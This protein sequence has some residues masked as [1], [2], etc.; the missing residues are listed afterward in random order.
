M[1]TYFIQIPPNKK[2][3]FLNLMKELDFV[4]ISENKT[5]TSLTNEEYI[6]G[7]IESEVD[8]EQGKVISHSDIKREVKS[9]RE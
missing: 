8:I 7:I 9:W 3:F 4:Q 1:E 5:E 6:R 2:D